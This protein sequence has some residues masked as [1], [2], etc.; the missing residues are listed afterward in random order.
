MHILKKPDLRRSLQPCAPSLPPRQGG[1]TTRGGD[2]GASLA[3]TTSSISS[4]VVILG[5]DAC[6]SVTGTF[7][8]PACGVIRPIPLPLKSPLEYILP[9]VVTSTRYYQILRGGSQQKCLASPCKQ[10]WF[11]LWLDVDPLIERAFNSSRITFQAAP[12]AMGLRLVSVFMGG[13]ESSRSI[14]HRACSRFDKS[15]NPPGR[16]L[17]TWVA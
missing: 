8:I 1:T 13:T 15:L 10:Y 7:W 14:S 5:H 11:L 12:L 16:L 3:I 9:E 4:P 2:T 17:K 6:V